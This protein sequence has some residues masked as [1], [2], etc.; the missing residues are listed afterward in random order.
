MLLTCN[1]LPDIKFSDR[2][3]W[4]RVRAVE[5]TSVFTDNPDP[6]DPCQFQIDE[7]LDAKLD[8]WKEAFIYIL[9]KEFAQFR[10]FVSMNQMKL[11][12]SLRNIRMRAITLLSSLMSV[13]LSLRIVLLVL[14]SM[15]LSQYIRIGFQEYWN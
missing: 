12:N 10:E 8:N 13:S 11:R 3:T 1:I 5:F 15:I 7:D 2:G 9:L 4:R 6:N 14:H